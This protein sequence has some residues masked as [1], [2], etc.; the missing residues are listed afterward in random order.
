LS[1]LNDRPRP[2]APGEKTQSQLKALGLAGKS[3][4]LRLLGDLG[5]AVQWSEQGEENS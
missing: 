1:A 5:A 4:A 2:A 3:N